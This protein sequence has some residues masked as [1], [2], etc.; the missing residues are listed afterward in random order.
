MK[1]NFKGR[2]YFTLICGI[3]CIVYAIASYGIYI[4]IGN[5]NQLFPL[6]YLVL[7]ISGIGMVMK[8]GDLI[9]SQ[10]NILFIIHFFWTID[11]FSFLIFG[12]YLLGVTSYFFTETLVFQIISLQHIIFIPL[13]LIC[14]YLIKSKKKYT[15]LLSILEVCIVFP[16]TFFF[17]PSQENINC[18]FKPCIDL[19]IPIPYFIAWILTFALLI[20]FTNWVIGMIPIFFKNNKK[21]R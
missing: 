19:N 10:I 14:L 5:W 18:V 7:L 2:D 20:I 1:T 4:Y 8:N 16:L 13:S 21:K 17:T 15:S 3:F 12:K 6:C 9:L 11:F